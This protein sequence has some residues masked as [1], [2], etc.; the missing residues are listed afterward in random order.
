VGIEDSGMMDEREAPAGGDDERGFAP[1]RVP[2]RAIGLWI[3]GLAVVFVAAV[4]GLYQLFVFQAQ[5]EVYAK[6]LQPVAPAVTQLRD[7]EAALLG[8]YEELEGRPGRYR[9]PIGRALELIANDPSLLRPVEG[10]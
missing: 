10:K 7:R 2:V 1:D 9:V 4:V 5:D 8:K 6:Q 3:G